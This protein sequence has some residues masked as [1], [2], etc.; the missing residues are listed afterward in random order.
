MTQIYTEQNLLLYYY[1][2]TDLFDTLEIE[3]ALEN[4]DHL[5]EMYLEL[6]FTL[7][8]LSTLVLSPSKNSIQ[9]ILN[10]SKQTAILY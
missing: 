6:K 10:Y 3:D 4:D 9:N 1:R 2:E 5:L 7:D 8:D